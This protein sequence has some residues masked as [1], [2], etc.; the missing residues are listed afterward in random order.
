MRPSRRHRFWPLF[1]AT[2]LHW[3]GLSSPSMA[4]PVCVRDL[5]VVVSTNVA[6]QICQISPQHV[7]NNACCS[8]KASPVWNPTTNKCDITCD[9]LDRCPGVVCTVLDQC[10]VVGVCDPFTGFCS[11]PGKPDN[12]PCDDGNACTIGD[13]CLSGQCT[14]GSPA[15]CKPPACYLSAGCDPQIGCLHLPAFAGT[16]C[17]N[18]APLGPCDASDTCDVTAV[19][20]PNVRHV[21]H[22]CRSVAGECDVAETCDGINPTCPADTF[23]PGGTPCGD[24]T[25]NDCT[26]PDQCDSG[27]ACQ[28]RDLGCVTTST[29]V[30]G[31]STTTATTPVMPSTST[32]LPFQGQCDHVTGLLRAICLINGALDNGLC[33]GE[34]VP[35][36][37]DRDLRARLNA[38]ASKFDSALVSDEPRRS[39]LLKGATRALAAMERKTAAA[40]KSKKPSKR[41]SS[42]C[43][44]KIGDSWR[45]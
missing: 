42:D 37:L 4:Q 25:S 1:L 14:P 35:S 22:V 38:I 19:C 18:T 27:G 34:P 36:K 41:I 2:G 26:E 21:S 44:G 31:A 8:M 9:F 29:T 15:T 23:E 17:G 24:P 7:A 28:P 45:R 43:Q 6:Q 32:T 40:L 20:R 30:I 13:E 33:D 16:P 12:S 11:N 5:E 3:L 10:H 39:R